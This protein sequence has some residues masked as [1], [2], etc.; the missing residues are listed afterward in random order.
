MHPCTFCTD[1]RD[2]PFP[3]SLVLVWT[4]FFLCSHSSC[5]QFPFSVP[6]P[7]LIWTTSRQLQLQEGPASSW[8][9]QGSVL[10]GRGGNWAFQ[11]LQGSNKFSEQ[12]F[13]KSLELSQLEERPQQ[14]PNMT[15]RLFLNK[16][17]VFFPKYALLKL[18][19]ESSATF[20]PLSA[21]EMTEL[22]SQTCLI[23]NPWFTCITTQEA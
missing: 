11:L 7:T 9:K 1:I 18:L 21:W 13:L 23:G 5:S 19:M 4:S 6:A 16:Y 20:S 8:L 15:Q 14:L 2:S 10:A 12:E 17:Q 3:Y 22:F